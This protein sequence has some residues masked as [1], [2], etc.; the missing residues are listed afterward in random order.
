MPSGKTYS[1]RLAPQPRQVP[2][3]SANQIAFYS[4]RDG[5]SGI[6]LMNADGSNQ[7]FLTSSYGGISWSAGSN[8][9]ALSCDGICVINAD[10]SN[11]TQVSNNSNDYAPAWSADGSKIAFT[12]NR[13]GK[14]EIYVMNVDGSN[15]TRLTMNSDFDEGPAWSPDGAKL[16]FTR[17]SDCI[18]L[19]NGETICFDA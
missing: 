7:S 12:S 14:P 8:K 3:V 19:G 15:P 6:Y 18:D 17:Y 2:P 5:N 1:P 11:L 16:A 9:I 4:N 10:G 13:A